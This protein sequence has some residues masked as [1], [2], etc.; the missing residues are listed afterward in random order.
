MLVSNA[1]TS[2]PFMNVTGTG[3]GEGRSH[4]TSLC[5]QRQR[6]TQGKWEPELDLKKDN[7]KK[8][9]KL[10][11]EAVLKTQSSSGSMKDSKPLGMKHA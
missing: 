7:I 3:G 1:H 6:K 2:L 9:K 5:I 8:D 11:L 10:H 4:F